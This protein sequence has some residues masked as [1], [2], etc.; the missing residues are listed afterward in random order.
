MKSYD[1]KLKQEKL[2]LYIFYLNLQFLN[3]VIIIKPKVPLT[4]T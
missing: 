4:R 3:H 2:L 1:I